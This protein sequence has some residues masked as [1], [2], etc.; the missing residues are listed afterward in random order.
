MGGLLF[1]EAYLTAT[2]QAIAQNHQW[3]LE[4]LELKVVMYH[5]EDL[6]EDS[7]LVSGLFIEGAQ[8]DTD[9]DKLVLSDE[10]RFALPTLKFT[11]IRVNK[12]DKGQVE[13]GEIL[14]PVYLNRSRANLLF[15]LKLKCG[16][17]PKTTLYQKGIALISCEN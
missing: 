16:K 6:D 3:S 12:A 14:V 17:I 2:R 5:K 10:M 4:E 1:P 8:W 15:S 7:F 11:W 13:E 9:S